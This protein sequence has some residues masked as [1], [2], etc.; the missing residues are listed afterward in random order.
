[1][2]AAYEELLRRA[3]ENAV[4][5]SCAE[6]LSWDELTHMPPGGA[7]NRGEQMALLFGL[8]HRRS[9]DP[10]LGELLSA[11]ESDCSL[12]TD[13][14][15][16]SARELRRRYDRAVR[17][18]PSLIEEQARVTSVA[19]REW[20]LA[21][22][23]DDFPR[24]LPWLERIL[25]LKR[26]EAEC[27]LADG[28]G[29]GKHASAYDALLDDY[30]PGATSRQLQSLFE[31]LRAGLMPLLDRIVGSPRW[32][33]TNVLRRDYPVDRQRVFVESVA[34]SLGFDFHQG[35]LDPTAHPFFSAIGP[36]DCRITTR[37]RQNE[38]GEAF[39]ATLHEVG[40]ALYEQGLDPAHYGTPLG[41]SAS[42]GI[43]ESQSRL[44]EQRV[45]RGLPFW[46]HFYPLAKQVFHE[47]LH[48]VSLETFHRA[49]N[50]VEPSFNRVRA[51]AVTYNL[52]IL[53]RFEIEQALVAGELPAADLPAAWREKHVQYLG[54]APPND[55]EGCLQDSHWA[56][57][58]FGYF[59]GYTLG[60]LIAAELFEAAERD[61]GDLSESFA[62]GEFSPLLTWLREKIHRHGQ[63]YSASELILRATGSP[64]DHRAYLRATAERQMACLSGSE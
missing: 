22:D 18:P 40:H 59:P 30:E 11:V 17:L 43:H 25:R 64:L 32:R 47:A 5:L 38:F 14:Q 50:H 8:H 24:A 1:M 51:D 21:K 39:F 3:R 63:R 57:G 27:L 12:L 16:A 49:V 10:R 9:S 61:L 28:K 2:H 37:Y 31:S 45:G 23:N 19:Q 29:G 13:G 55:A 7:E 62:V 26:A 33:P 58:M 41:E 15:L 46:R 54:L 34:A 36:G 52:H 4:L 6:L 20:E 44:W 35:R 48:G 60:N 56:G 42:L 53:L